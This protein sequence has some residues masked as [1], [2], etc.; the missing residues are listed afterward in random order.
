MNT[1]SFDSFCK[2][3]IYAFGL[4]LWEVARRCQDSN[5]MFDEYKPPFYDLVNPDPSFEEMRKVVCVDQARP[6]ISKRW[7]S[8]EASLSFG[9]LAIS[10]LGRFP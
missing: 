7:Q 1:D 5:G 8:C 3:D 4:V 10:L 2:A 6:I 9:T